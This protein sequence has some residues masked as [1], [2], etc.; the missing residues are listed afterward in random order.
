MGLRGAALQSDRGIPHQA[1]SQLP[2][3]TPEEQA[4]AGH[5][6]GR[7]EI[8]GARSATFSKAKKWANWD[9]NSI[10]M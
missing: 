9:G 10:L 5:P 1:G 4:V 8:P 2:C 7:R 6:K 3:P